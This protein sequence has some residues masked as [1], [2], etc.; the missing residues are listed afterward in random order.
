L[1]EDTRRARK[2]KTHFRLPGKLVSFH[3]HNENQRLPKILTLMREGKIFALVSDA[4]TPLISDPGLLLTQKMIE[5]GMA[6]THIPGPNAVITA[7]VLSGFP[8]DRFVYYG[9]L[10]VKTGARQQALKE[11][12]NKME[13]LVLFESPERVFSLVREI[14]EFLGNRRIALC[15]EMTKA[16]E[17]ILRG[18]VSE[19]LQQLSG[20][21]FRGEFTVVIAPGTE[22]TAAIMPDEIIRSRFA[23]LQ[24]EGRSRKEAL[25]KL[26]KESG[27]P[28]NELYD[29]LI[30]NKNT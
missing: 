14:G 11:L 4:G 27:R 25:G 22:T 3:E 26:V 20:R 1:C 12:A 8:V 9:F 28:R 6:F 29:L 17:E 21:R 30:K 2:L 24:Q 5:A 13:T 18:S 10:P 16:H 23:Q 7:L 15:R 19:I